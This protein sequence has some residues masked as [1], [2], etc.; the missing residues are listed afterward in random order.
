MNSFTNP[1]MF[2]KTSYYLVSVLIISMKDSLTESLNFIWS[3]SKLT[4]LPISS[5]VRFLVY[6]PA[7]NWEDT[8]NSNVIERVSRSTFVEIVSRFFSIFSSF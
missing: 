4:G 5:R 3:P 1:K 8:E 2:P 6:L 7:S